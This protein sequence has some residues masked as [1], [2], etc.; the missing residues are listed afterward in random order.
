M[1]SDIKIKEL[2]REELIEANLCHS[3][4]HSTHEAYAVI[5]E[6]IEEMQEAA[7]ECVYALDSI[8][9]ASVKVD[10]YTYYENDLMMLKSSAM[11]TAKEAIQVAAMAQKALDSLEEEK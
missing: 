1:I 11:H 7:D 3:L 2:I 4:F 6:E 9:S 5:K 8:W 10:N